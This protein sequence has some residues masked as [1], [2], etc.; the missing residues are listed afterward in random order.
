VKAAGNLDWT[1]DSG[2]GVK[3]RLLDVSSTAVFNPVLVAGGGGG[4]NSPPTAAFTYRCTDLAC[5]FTDASTDSDGSVASWSWTFGDGA[6][7]MDQS[8]SHSYAAGGTFTVSLVVTDNAGATGTTSQ[9]LTVTAPSP[10]GIAL[11]VK[12]VKV[13]NVKYADLLWTGATSATVDVHK[14]GDVLIANT[15]ND[16]DYRDGPLAKTGTAT[17]KVCEAGTVTCSNPVTITW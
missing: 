15:A 13:K 1:D 14:G 10:G 12:L 5:T 16:G 6:S 3:E 7:S 11:A 17:Y 9:A 8:P 2:D 4:A